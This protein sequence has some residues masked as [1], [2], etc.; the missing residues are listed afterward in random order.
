MNR[1]LQLAGVAVCVLAFAGV[2]C[3]EA[4]KKAC[5]DA[6]ETSCIQCHAMKKTCASLAKPDTDWRAVMERM[7][8]K[9]KLDKTGSDKI[10]ACLRDAAV[11]EDLCPGDK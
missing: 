1:W 2:A 7:G 5:R 6:M 3:A 11:R 10:G 9:A 4:D 8:A